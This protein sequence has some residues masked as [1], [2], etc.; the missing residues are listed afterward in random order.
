MK[1]DP[2]FLPGSLKSV[3]MI[4]FM[5]HSNLQIALKPCVNFITGRNGSGKSSILVAISVG[6]GSNIRITG[7][8]TSLSSL[9]KD[10]QSE[11]Q[12]IVILNNGTEGYQ[13]ER[14]GNEIKITRKIHKSSSSFEIQGFP[15]NSL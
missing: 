2:V 12:I 10:G 4:N 8:G 5:K 14:Y 13:Y 6:L 11:A 15:K 3:Q 1:N 7:R 9:I